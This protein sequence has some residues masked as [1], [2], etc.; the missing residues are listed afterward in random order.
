M[1]GDHDL[2]PARAADRALDEALVV[3]RAGG[4]DALAAP[5]GEAQ[6]AAAADELGEPG[7]EVAADHVAVA[8]RR[9]PARHQAERDGVGRAAAGGA[10][11]SSKLSRQR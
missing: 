8:R 5:V 10:T 11:A 6:R 1:V 7:R 4:I 3:V 9:R 2:G